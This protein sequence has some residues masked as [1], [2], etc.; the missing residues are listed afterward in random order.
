MFES[1]S[2]LR[3]EMHKRGEGVEQKSIRKPSHLP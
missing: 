3:Y 1:V 2:A